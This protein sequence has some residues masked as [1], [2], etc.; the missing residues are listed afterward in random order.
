MSRPDKPITI[1]L[2]EDKPDYAASFKTTA[3]KQRII[4][5]SVDNGDELLELLKDNPRK[6][7]FVVL[8]ARAYMQEGQTEGTED[9]MNLLPIMR[10]LDEIK[11]Q[12]QIT[13]PYCI[14]TGFADLKLRLSN[15]VDCPIFEKG[16]ETDLIDHIWDEYLKTDNAILLMAHPEIFGVAIDHFDSTAYA[17]LTDLFTDKKHLSSSIAAR[18]SNLSSLRRSLEHLMDIVNRNYLNDTVP[19]S[20]PGSRLGEIA[21]FL[22]DQDDIPVHVFCTITSIRKIAGNFGSHTPQTAE[23]IEGYPSGELISGLACSMKD[24]FSWANKLI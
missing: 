11:Q 24:V 2:Y 9:E 6:Y 20:S 21:K 19:I 8:D 17:V 18:V 14:N 4:V 15:K 5:K 12:Y 10:S 16:N 13:L 7:Q 22:N 23:L 3:Q 1:L